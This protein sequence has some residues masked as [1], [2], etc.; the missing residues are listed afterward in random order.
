MEFLISTTEQ[1]KLK[2]PHGRG[3]KEP[4]AFLTFGNWS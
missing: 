1:N 4:R 2:L 3:K